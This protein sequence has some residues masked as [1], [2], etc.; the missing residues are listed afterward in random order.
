MRAVVCQ[1]K[2]GPNGLIVGDIDAP[3]MIEGGVRIAVYA[4][5]LN[6]SDLMII[7]GD[8]QI[9]PDFPF[10]PGAEVSGIVMECA[11]GVYHV[12]PGDRVLAILDYGGFSEQ[13]VARSSDVY[14]IPAAMD[15]VT[16]AGFPV[17][18][19]T[20]H[21]ALRE[22]LDL[23]AGQTV[24]INGAA[25]GVGLTAVEISHILKVRVIATAGGPEKLA[26]AKAAGASELI[27]YRSE[28]IRERVKA[29]TG[30]LGVEAVYDPVG[31]KTFEASLRA[32]CAGARMLIIGFAAGEVQQIP[33][34]ILLIKNITAIGFHWGAYRTLD[35]EI[36]ERSFLELFDWYREGRLKP[37]VSHTFELSEVTEALEMIRLRKSTGKVVL[38]IQA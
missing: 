2:C 25:G 5:G 26:I 22:K 4:A 36:L 35:P 21:V 13:V 30:G 28:D 17:A 24:L 18:Y 16:A 31:G 38:T 14:L 34:N 11:P 19:G 27:D 32:T 10:T 8:Y 7:R 20:S 6:Y 33:A 12:K 29:L 37:H 9:K 23:Q 15:F 1:E 3:P